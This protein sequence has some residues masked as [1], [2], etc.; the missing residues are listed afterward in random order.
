MKILSNLGIALS[1]EIRIMSAY[2]GGLY[3][4][5]NDSRRGAVC[6]RLSCLSIYLCAPVD[7]AFSR[8]DG[9]LDSRL[10][11]IPAVHWR[12]KGSHM[13]AIAMMVVTAILV[14]LGATTLCVLSV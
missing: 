2:Q 6:S 10:C 14:V 9:G 4:K 11:R 5:R 12:V 8:S 1:R 7:Q 13:K 3:V